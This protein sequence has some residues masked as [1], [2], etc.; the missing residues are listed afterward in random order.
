MGKFY[1]LG[2]ASGE[3]CNC[4]IDTLRQTIPGIMRNVSRVRAELEQRHRNRQTQAPGSY[5]PFDLW[6]GILDLLG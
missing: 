5:L 4:L 6:D 3:G 1:Y 2:N